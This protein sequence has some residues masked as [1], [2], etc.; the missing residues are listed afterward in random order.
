MNAEKLYISTI[1]ADAP[2][3]ARRHG[4]GLEIAE[5]CTA[6]NMDEG[7][8]ENDAAVREKLAGVAR[9]TLHAPFSELFPC[10]VDP[11]ARELARERYAQAMA[12]AVGYGARKLIIHGGFNPYLYFPEWYTAQSAPF[13]REFMGDVPQGLEICLENVTEP[14]PELL[15]EIIA[16]VDDPRLKMCLDVGHANAYSLVPVGEWIAMLGKRIAHVHLHNNDGSR[17]AHAPLNAG[18]MDI[19][20]ILELLDEHAPEAEICI[21]SVDALSCLETLEET[22]AMEK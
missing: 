17:D 16:A 14:A 22:G 15:C 2:E 21:E 8:A 3:L 5:Y 6:C 1:A 9:R 18:S 19:P 11:R 13:W 4:L 12:L 10:A 20:R 7:F